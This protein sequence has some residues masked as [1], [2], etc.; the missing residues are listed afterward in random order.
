MVGVALVVGLCVP[1]PPPPSLPMGGERDG[2]GEELCET[3]LEEDPPP[4][5]LPSPLPPPLDKDPVGVMV[6][7]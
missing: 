4:S 3:V 2:V 6:G 1:P 5:H 7:E